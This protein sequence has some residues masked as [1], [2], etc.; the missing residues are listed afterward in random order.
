MTAI[1]KPTV[2]RLMVL[3]PDRLSHLL[4]KGEITDRYYN[5]GDLFDEVHLVATNDDKPNLA[6]LQ[7]TVG[8]ARLVLHNLPDPRNVFVSTLGW[9]PWLLNFW[10]QEAVDLARSL[11]PSLIRC[12]GA[13][14]NTF[15]A[16]RIKKQLGIPYVVSLH[17]NPDVDVRGRARGFVKRFVTWAQQDI[18]RIG[19]LNAD[20]VMPVYRP[21]VPYL[22]RYGVTR[23]EVCY[24][25]LNPTNLR[26]KDDY[27]L[28]D[29]VRVIS[30]GRQ[31]EEKDPECLIKA[32]AEMPN[33]HL[34]IVGNG[35]GH[36]RLKE[37]AAD[38]GIG[39]R[40]EF[41]RSLPNDELCRR[42]PEFDIFAT[43]SEY[44]ELSKSVIEPLLT[45]LP[46]VINRRIGEPVPE[47]TSDICILVE[48]SAAAYRQA[49]DRLIAD[50]DFRER[51]GRAAYTRAQADW[52][53]AITEA[54]FASIY[55][56][57]MKNAA[58]KQA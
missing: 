41:I 52:A 58:V 3:I 50:N 29:P 39:A 32:A 33:V 38:C 47:L 31:F 23:Y 28:H 21:I 10:A 44:W 34:T 54:K 11:Q 18:E 49:L 16:A 9:R 6:G 12:H 20:L 55:R 51:L 17:I 56:S 36:E 27:R 35:A 30:V 15:A 53:P 48:N 25:A 22:K 40:V 46:L 24:N 5:P 1:P 45:G 7:M 26:R 19:L 42:L 2:S 4:D 43:H 8:R 14:A 37:V 13:L 57:V